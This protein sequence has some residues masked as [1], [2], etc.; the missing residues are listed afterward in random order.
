MKNTTFMLTLALASIAFVSTARAGNETIGL[1]LAAKPT[2]GPLFKEVHRPLSASLTVKVSN[3]ETESTILPLKQANVTFPADMGFFPDPKKTPVCPDS[4]LSNTS[5]LAA[6]IPAVVALCPKSVVGTGTSTVQ[7]AQSKEAFATVTDPQLIIFN[8]GRNKSGRPKIKIYGFSKTV[9]SGLLMQGVL[10]RNGE[11]K[12]EIGVLPFDSSV[13]EF[14][15][16]IPG[17][18]IEVPN[19]GSGQGASRYQGLDPAYLRGKCSTGDWRA[20]GEFLLGARAFPSGIPLGDDF[21]IASNSFNLPCDGRAGRANLKI[22]RISGP[23]Q[24]APGKKARFLLKVAN[25]GTATARRVRLKA[26]G[27]VKGSRNLAKLAPGQTRQIVL[28]TRA[29]ARRAS[30]RVVFAVTA[31]KTVR[32]ESVRKMKV[33]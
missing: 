5:N 3:P 28:N 12:V 19:P 18:V 16:G 10:A 4:E 26:T 24:V 31:N 21:L 17:E 30:G 29:R 22:R 9:N 13:S 32:K 20:S 14:T 11:L 8:A 2:S 27:L 23:R 33:G 6:G 7:L 15:L 1:S 25:P